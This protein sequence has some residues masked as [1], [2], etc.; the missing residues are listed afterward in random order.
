MRVWPYKKR[1][2][3]SAEQNHSW[4][5]GV[6]LMIPSFGQLVSEEIAHEDL[7]YAYCVKWILSGNNNEG[8]Y[9]ITIIK[10]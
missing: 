8:I 9:V 4:F 5:G 2:E 1:D 3:V 6:F 10:Q 7:S